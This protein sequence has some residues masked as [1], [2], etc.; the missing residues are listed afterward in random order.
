M[1]LFLVW[2]WSSMTVS[3]S[4][5]TQSLGKIRD[6]E[7]AQGRVVLEM[8]LTITLQQASSLEVQE[9]IDSLFKTL[10]DWIETYQGKRIQRL[11]LVDIPDFTIRLHAHRFV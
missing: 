4:F 7:A 2:I 1:E 10:L 6:E 11:P 5:S 8:L 3:L 9:A